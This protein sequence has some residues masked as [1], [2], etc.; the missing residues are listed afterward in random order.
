MLLAGLGTEG[1]T[2]AVMVAHGFNSGQLQELV[3]V[4]F[5]ENSKNGKLSIT[6][7]GQRAMVRP[8]GGAR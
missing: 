2:E 8:R 4:E 3:R 1:C 5:A 7:A 6:K